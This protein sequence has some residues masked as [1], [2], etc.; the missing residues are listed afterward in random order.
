[1]Y[2]KKKG[3]IIAKEYGDHAISGTTEDRPAFQQM[4]SEW[5]S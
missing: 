3:F 5:M 2:A 1:M 4:L